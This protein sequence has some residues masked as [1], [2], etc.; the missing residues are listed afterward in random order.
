LLCGG[1]DREKAAQLTKDGLT[2]SR[3]DAKGVFYERMLDASY[4]PEKMLARNHG[5]FSAA[6]YKALSLNLLS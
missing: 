3:K 1:D 4:S 6:Q 2:Q 5:Y